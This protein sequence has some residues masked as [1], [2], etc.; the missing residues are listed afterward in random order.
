MNVKNRI[1]SFEENPRLSA[2]FA[3]KLFPQLNQTPPRTSVQN[4]TKG[5]PA[6]ADIPKTF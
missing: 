4:A 5:K 2:S 1:P 3:C 6:K